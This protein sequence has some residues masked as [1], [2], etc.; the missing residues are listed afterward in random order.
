MKNISRNIHRR[1]TSVNVIELLFNVSRFPRMDP[2]FTF[3]HSTDFSYGRQCDYSPNDRP[4]YEIGSVRS[5]TRTKREI[6][7]ISVKIREGRDR[8]CS[9]SL[10]RLIGLLEI[11]GEKNIDKKKKKIQSRVNYSRTIYPPIE[12]PRTRANHRY[13]FSMAIICSVD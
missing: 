8:I 5:A 9:L 1:D 7:R 12:I 4:E 6:G 3:K 11:H 13:C 10:S 2:S